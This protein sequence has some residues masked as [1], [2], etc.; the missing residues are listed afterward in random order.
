ML[1]RSL[2]LVSLL[3]LFA[4]TLPAESLARGSSNRFEPIDIFEIEWAS[5]PRISTDGT[6]IVYVRNFMDIMKDRY[7]STCGWSTSTAPTIVRSPPGS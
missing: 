1:K 6:R 2:L 7:R 3:A 5:D 4:P